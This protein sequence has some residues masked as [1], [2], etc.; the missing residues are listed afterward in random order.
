MAEFGGYASRLDSLGPGH[1]FLRAILA[2]P[3][4]VLCPP[5]TTVNF[6]PFVLLSAA[7]DHDGHIQS[8]IRREKGA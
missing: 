7:I 1:A 2:Q 6:S 5:S 4:D 3:P 8:K